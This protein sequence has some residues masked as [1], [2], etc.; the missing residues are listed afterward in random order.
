MAKQSGK[1]TYVEF[2][3]V[4]LSVTLRDFTITRTQNEADSTAGADEWENSVPTTKSIKATAT[5][6]VLKKS[7]GGAAVRS[8]LAEGTED[9]LLWGFEGNAAGKSKGGFLARVSKLDIKANYKEVVMYDLE[10][11]MAGETLL[12][13]DATATW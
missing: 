1:D 2:G 3:G 4:D 6:V 11:S 13:D 7:D 12:F 5:A 9:N 10:F 8:I